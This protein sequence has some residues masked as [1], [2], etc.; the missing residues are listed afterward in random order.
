MVLP[1]LAN[2]VI[3]SLGSSY[4]SGPGIDPQIVPAASRSGNN[5]AHLLANKLDNATLTDLSISGATLTTIWKQSQ[6]AGGTTFPPQLDGVPEDS[7]LV[8]ILG[9]GNDVNYNGGLIADSNTTGDFAAL[10]T[11]FA[12]VL[13]AIHTKAPSAHVIGVTYLTVL[14]GDVI[15]VPEEGAN[16]KFNAS[17]VA[18]HQGVAEKLRQ[19][20]LGAFEGREAWS[21]VLDVVDPSWS[22]ALG[23]SDPW[24]NG[25][26]TDPKYH[27]LAE[28]H[29][30][31]A[32]MLYERLSS[33]TKR[34][35][36]RKELKARL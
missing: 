14:G 35:L 4:A 10:Q 23:S 24:M 7:D 34:K 17:R 2:L 26:D 33:E 9:G 15:P 25:G 19:A 13:D 28:G 31:I 8:L 32:D 6:T 1:S 11:R 3:A 20:T 27:P 12:D 22:H 5:Y 21:E 18:Y 36:R 29:V 30:A 16:V